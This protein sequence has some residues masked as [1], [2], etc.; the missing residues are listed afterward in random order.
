MMVQLHTRVTALLSITL[1]VCRPGAGQQRRGRLSDLPGPI[2]R[3]CTC[4]CCC[5]HA[6]A[7]L[8]P[9]K[10]QLVCLRAGITFWLH[11]LSSK[12]SLEHAVPAS[13]QRTRPSSRNATTVSIWPASSSGWS[14][15]RRAQCAAVRWSSTSCSDW[16]GPLWSHGGAVSRATLPLIAGCCLWTQRSVLTWLPNLLMP[17]EMAKHARGSL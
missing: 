3:G 11:L 14:A 1:F 10:S 6:A 5:C 17:C 12:H 9:E 7:M 16:F 8:P 4:C 2:Y 15:A 13:L